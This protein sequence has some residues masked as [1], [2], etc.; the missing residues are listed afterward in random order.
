MQA[1]QCLRL[2]LAGVAFVATATVCAASA[3]AA[4]GGLD[5]L[6]GKLSSF[7]GGAGKSA[8]LDPS[9]SSFI[10]LVRNG[11][12]LANRGSAGQREVGLAFLDRAVRT[13]NRGADDLD[14]GAVGEL[15]A[16]LGRLSP[17][18]REPGLRLLARVA[19]ASGNAIILQD[20]FY[21]LMRAFQRL[22]GTRE[23]VAQAGR[24]FNDESAGEFEWDPMGFNIAPMFARAL[25][26]IR[27]A[28]AGIR[29]PAI[30]VDTLEALVRT[31]YKANVRGPLYGDQWTVGALK[32]ELAHWTAKGG[33]APLKVRFLDGQAALVRQPGVPGHTPI[34]PLAPARSKN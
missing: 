24:M 28:P 3:R 23:A 22:G 8:P 6:S 18:N 10:T 32:K 20:T 5:K 14:V 25:K 33:K 13:F 21:S 16:E 34:A 27:T 9:S 31:F 4:G 2:M 30:T 29:R 17:K 26:T 12:E 7:L 15:A 1:R 11:V 19:R